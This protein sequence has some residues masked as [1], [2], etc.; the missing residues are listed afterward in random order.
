MA[1]Y[2]LDHSLYSS[3][4]LIEFV[5]GI[6]GLQNAVQVERI[7][8][9]YSLDHK[10]KVITP[11]QGNMLLRVFPYSDMESKQIEV[12]V[13]DR[14]RQMGVMCSTPLGIGKLDED[15]GYMIVSYLEGEDASEVLPRL[16]EQQQWSIGMQ[17]GAAL[18]CIHRLPVEKQAES[19]YSRKSRKHRRYVDKYREC[20]VVMKQDQAILNFIEDHLDCM[21]GRPDYFQHD[22][23]HPA[24]LL[25]NQGELAGVIDFNRADQGDPVHEF[26]KLGLF[27]TETS[28]PYSIGQVQGYLDGNEPN[29]EFWRMYSLYMAMAL[30]SSVVWIQH[31]KPEETDEMMMKMDRVRED[32]E[33]FRSMIPRWYT[34]NR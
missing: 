9:G 11:H 27:A 30:V 15:N 6:P 23:F 4:G 18:K 16:N 13:L 24:N 34:M 28:I 8:K 29:E 1:E 17:A 26:L 10:F 32:H 33:D 25:I 20:S 5:K 3:V 21:K 22:D 2:R 31:V 7:S 12:Q 19:W 14:V